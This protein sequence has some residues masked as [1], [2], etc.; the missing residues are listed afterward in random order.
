MPKKIVKKSFS[1]PKTLTDTIT[2]TKV[3]VV[4]ATLGLPFGEPAI[5]IAYD[6]EHPKSSGGVA[7]FLF[8]SDQANRVQRL[9]ETFDEGTA[10]VRL[11]E[12]IEKAKQDPA[13]VAFA[14]ELEKTVTDAI[15][16]Y[17]RKFL[18]NYQRIVRFLREE[19]NECVVIGG[20]PVYDESGNFVGKQGHR[21][22]CLPDRKPAK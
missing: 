15:V 1:R 20:D 4:F 14:T 3:A 21:I 7:H 8:Q 18:E 16:V 17:G 6:E 10:D 12:L 2:N 22:V 5:W 9:R 19:A 11:D 13:L